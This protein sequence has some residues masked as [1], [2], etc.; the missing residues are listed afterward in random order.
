MFSNGLS[1]YSFS[2]L[3][4]ETFLIGLSLDLSS[5]ISTARITSLAFDALSIFLMN[6]FVFFNC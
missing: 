6:S 3:V 2:I 4:T 5:R 1:D